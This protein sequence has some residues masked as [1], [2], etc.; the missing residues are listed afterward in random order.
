MSKITQEMINCGECRVWGTH[1]NGEYR[2]NF[3]FPCE[4]H[5]PKECKCQQDGDTTVTAFCPLHRNL[6]QEANGDY[7][8]T[9]ARM[10][11]KVSTEGW[12]GA[13]SE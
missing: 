5:A 3:C 9:V 10:K 8:Y 1:E 7:V 13:M 11:M 12:C 2:A 6:R 4:E